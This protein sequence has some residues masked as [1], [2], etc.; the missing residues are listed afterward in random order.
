MS[1]RATAELSHVKRLFGEEITLATNHDDS[2][3]ATTATPT[4]SAASTC[5]EMMP[6]QSVTLL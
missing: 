3:T 6:A 5:A 1:E 2:R 4:P